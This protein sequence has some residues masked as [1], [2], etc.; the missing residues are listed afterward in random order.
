MAG[1]GI[2]LAMQGLLREHRRRAD[3]HFHAPFHV[4][5]YISIGKEEGRGAG[6]DAVQHDARAYRQVEGGDPEPQDRRRDPA[7]LRQDPAAAAG[8]GVAYDTDIAVALAAIDGVLRATRACCR[9]QRRW[10][11]FRSWP[12]RA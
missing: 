12:I 7:Q 6:R 9:N 2:A 3:D 4:G 10:S 5:D 11:V 8:V 1:A